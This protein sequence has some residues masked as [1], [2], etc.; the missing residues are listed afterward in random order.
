M[1]TPSLHILMGTAENNIAKKVTQKGGIT[2]ATFINNLPE[3][4]HVLF[5]LLYPKLLG[6]CLT[7]LQKY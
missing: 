3:R 7:V 1:R 4:L 6:Q 2:V 5:I